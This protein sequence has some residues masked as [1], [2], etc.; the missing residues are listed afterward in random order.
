[1]EKFSVR[2]FDA[3]F[4]HSWMLD[5]EGGVVK[6]VRVDAGTIQVA[7]S[8]TGGEAQ[9][10]WY[11]LQT[12]DWKNISLPTMG[13]RNLD[14]H[15][16]CLGKLIRRVGRITHK[17]FSE[18]TVD[19]I[20]VPQVVGVMASLGLNQE[21]NYRANF[22]GIT[23][24]VAQ[25]AYKPEYETLESAVTQMKNV[26]R[27]TGFAINADMAVVFGLFA[28][29]AFILL[30]KDM[31]AAHSEDGVRWKLLSDDYKAPIERKLGKLNYV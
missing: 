15:G 26:P 28:H 2:D 19:V 6:M 1:M 29:N 11:P 9:A 16:R 4:R 17:G 8:P 23:Q 24:R 27:A 10:K 13:Y 25:E 22:Q 18:E 31:E 5:P 14:A 3:Y 7:L 21:K 20:E 30:W 12:L